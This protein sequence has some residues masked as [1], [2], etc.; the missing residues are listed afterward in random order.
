MNEENQENL[1]ENFEG[2]NHS[3]VIIVACND[4]DDEPIIF[5]KGDLHLCTVLAKYA[6]SLLKSN[7]IL[8]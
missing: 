1:P 3:N 4:S 5:Q 6:F 8:I 7:L 2:L